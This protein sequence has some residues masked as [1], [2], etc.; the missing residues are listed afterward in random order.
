MSQ[1]NRLN[2]L[3]TRTSSRRSNTSSHNLDL[4]QATSHALAP[5]IRYVSSSKH[6]V[7]VQGLLIPSLFFLRPFGNCRDR[8]RCSARAGSHSRTQIS[9]QLR[10][11][12]QDRHHHSAGLQNQRGYRRLAHRRD[13]HDWLRLHLGLDGRFFDVQ[14]DCD[15]PG[16]YIIFGSGLRGELRRDC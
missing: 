13:S 4:Y 1:V 8:P 15:G 14:A 16:Q 2:S 3:G 11:P 12:R 5:P 7:L 10:D 9:R 6:H